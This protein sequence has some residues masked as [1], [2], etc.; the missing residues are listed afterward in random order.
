MSGGLNQRI[1]IAL[2]MLM[3]QKL[4]LADEPTSALDAV[5]RRTV[6]DEL[7][8]MR[9]DC[10]IAQMIV[11]H[12]FALASYVAD[13]IAV[14]HRGMIVELAPAQ[15][16]VSSPLHPYTKALLGSVPILGG[17]IPAF[18]DVDPEYSGKLIESSPGHFVLTE[19]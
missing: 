2:V 18:P 13:R 4:L 11:T 16:L 15:E 17:C 12:D 19:V 9:S 8:A 3:Q 10:G 5:T 1:A 14:M 7:I 6:A